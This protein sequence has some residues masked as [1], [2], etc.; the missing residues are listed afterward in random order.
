MAEEAGKQDSEQKEKTSAAV[1]SHVRLGSMKV[2]VGTASSA[3][4]HVSWCNSAS[5]CRLGQ[6]NVTLQ[7]GRKRRSSGRESSELVEVLVAV[8]VML[9]RRS[10]D[11]AESVNGATL[12]ADDQL[13]KHQR[14]A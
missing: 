14:G 3:R 1:L 9:Q 13:A 11:A 4:S 7:G 10:K 2:M 5:L 6:N 12:R 8:L